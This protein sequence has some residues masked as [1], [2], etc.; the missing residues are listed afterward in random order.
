M[1]NKS[2]EEINHSESIRKALCS[3]RIISGLTRD[4]L[5]KL[6]GV[7]SDQ[8][9]YWMSGRTLGA[10]HEDHLIKALD[11]VRIIDRGS[12]DSNRST[13][14]EVTDGISALDLLANKNFEEVCSRL[15]AGP[16][17][18]DRVI[19]ELSSEEKAARTPLPPEVLANALNDSIHPTSGELISSRPAK[20]IRV[21]D[22]NKLKGKI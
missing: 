7:S 3:L 1:Q 12:A 17:R 15:G 19:G 2:I 13:L 8:I 18:R 21:K 4:H 5:A 6:F 14:L 9:R 22:S 10:E 16:G 20:T 11:I